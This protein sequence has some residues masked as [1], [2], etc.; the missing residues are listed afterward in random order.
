[1]LCPSNSQ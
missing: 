1:M